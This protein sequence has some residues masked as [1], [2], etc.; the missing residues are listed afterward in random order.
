MSKIKVN[1]TLKKYSVDTM[2][3][4]IKKTSI[5]IDKFL[6]D[7]VIYKLRRKKEYITNKGNL[8]NKW[9]DRRY[10]QDEIMSKSDNHL[11]SNFLSYQIVIYGIYDKSK[12]ENKSITEIGNEILIKKVMSRTLKDEMKIY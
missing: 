5:L 1:L 7:I 2:E 12:V 11:M 4:S 10:F 6:F 3:Y 8:K 9:R